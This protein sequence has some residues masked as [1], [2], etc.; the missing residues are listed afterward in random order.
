M[1][2]KSINKL[3]LKRATVSN[4]ENINGGLASPVKEAQSIENTTCMSMSACDTYR[5]N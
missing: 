3:S 2:T 1:K 5:A 4:L